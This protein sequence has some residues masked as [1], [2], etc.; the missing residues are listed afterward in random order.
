MLFRVYLVLLFCCL[1]AMAADKVFEQ[2]RPD[3][4]IE[5]RL[6]PEKAVPGEIRRLEIDILTKLWFL[7]APVYPDI[8]VEGAMVIAPRSFGVNFTEHRNGVDYTGQRQEYL[9]FPQRQGAFLVRPIEVGLIVPGKDGFTPLKASVTSAQLSFITDEFLLPQYSGSNQTSLLAGREFLLEEFYTEDADIRVGDVLSRNISLQARDTLG[10][11]LPSFGQDMPELSKK[12]TSSFPGG[13]LYRR[14][15]DLSDELN[16]GE[17]TAQRTEIWEYIF[18]EAGEYTLPGIEVVFWDLDSKTWR[19]VSLKP[20]SILVGAAIT[21]SESESI[22]D[23]FVLLRTLPEIGAIVLLL[24][25]ILLIFIYVRMSVSFSAKFSENI[26]RLRQSEGLHLL[27]LCILTNKVTS[28][29]WRSAFYTW[30]AHYPLESKRVALSENLK[31][32]LMYFYKKSEHGQE[33]DSPPRKSKLLREVWAYRQELRSIA[34]R[35]YT[36]PKLS[37]LNPLL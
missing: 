3:Q 10:M 8:Q 24:G 22:L 26:I 27:R 20:R 9:I 13:R 32:T 4:I 11:F 21:K 29:R 31:A 36:P 34:L 5:I 33:I 19:S 23:E 35:K 14:I 2:A 30:L 28:D 15:L 1:D 18:E 6:L 17:L 37:E 16:R 25:F 12:A 7:N